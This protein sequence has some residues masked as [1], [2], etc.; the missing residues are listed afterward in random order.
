MKALS[1][2]FLGLLT[3]TASADVTIFDV[4]KNLPMSD[5]EQV[6]RDYYISG[7]NESGLAVGQII[8]VQRRTPLYDT[9]QNRSAG[10]LLLKVAKIKIIHVQRGLAVARLHTEFGRE[11]S[12]IVE[13]PFIMIGDRLDLSSATGGGASAKATG[14]EAEAETPKESRAEAPA[15][16]VAQISVNAVELSSEAPRPKQ[17]PNLNPDVQ[18]PVLQ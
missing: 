11:N 17:E 6:Y 15:R 10:D 1:L 8:T 5:T 16:P 2:C 4:R 18:A 14:G 9:Y 7:G 13:D 3:A 12:P